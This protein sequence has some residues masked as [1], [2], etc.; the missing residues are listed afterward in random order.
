MMLVWGWWWPGGYIQRTKTSVK[1]S[2]KSLN[3]FLSREA[4][5]ERWYRIPYPPS[6]DSGSSQNG[7]GVHIVTE[8][9][10]NPNGG[11]ARA[12]ALVNGNGIASNGTSDAESDVPDITEL[13]IE[14]EASSDQYGR[15]TV[16]GV[17][18]LA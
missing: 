9:P 1:Y 7:P 13:K 5:T 14:F 3:V 10:A 8:I 12:A 6:V 16:Y 18:V 15:V 17:E 2:G 4:I 11:G